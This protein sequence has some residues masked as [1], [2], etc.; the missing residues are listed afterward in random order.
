MELMSACPQVPRKGLS[1]HALQGPQA[2]ADLAALSASQNAASVPVQLLTALLGTPSCDSLLPV[3]EPPT[4]GSQADSVMADLCA[5]FGLNH[6]QAHALAGVEAWF[7]GQVCLASARHPAT[8]QA[9]EH[10]R[11]RR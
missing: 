4:A 1:V 8:M 10:A 3:A 6:E 9:A 7:T 5:K 2:A 11:R